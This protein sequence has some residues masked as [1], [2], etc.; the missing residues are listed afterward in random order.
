MNE[1]RI[2]TSDS[3]GLGLVDALRHHLPVLMEK[4]QTPGLNIAVAD[5]G[6]L[7][8]E[9][10]FGFADVVSGRPM[11]ADSVYRSGSLGKTYT[12]TAIMILV[13]RGVIALHDAI[14]KHLPFG[15]HNPLGGREIT[16][17]DLMTHM[18]GL[19]E[20]GAASSWAPSSCS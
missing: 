14:N 6:K 3:D 20:D 12:A 4:H 17:H 19:S 16:V 2:H 9:A 15:V 13:N 10:G 11:T 18:S 5:K 7:V 1:E 8:W